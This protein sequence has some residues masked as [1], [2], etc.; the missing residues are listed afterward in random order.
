MWCCDA[1]AGEIWVAGMADGSCVA[2][3]GRLGGLNAAQCS[4]ANSMWL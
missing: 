4:M 2:L 3:P 1:I